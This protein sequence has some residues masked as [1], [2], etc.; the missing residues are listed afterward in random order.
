MISLKKGPH[1]NRKKG[2]RK[3]KNSHTK[4]RPGS[5]SA[6]RQKMLIRNPAKVTPNY[7]LD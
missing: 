3:K 1:D 7:R 6:T 2:K 5:G 4:M